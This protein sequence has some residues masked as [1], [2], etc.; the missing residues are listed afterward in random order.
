MSIRLSEDLQRS[1]LKAKLPSLPAMAVQLLGLGQS[2]SSNVAALTEIV[3]NDPAVTAAL[4]RLANAAAYHRIKPAE[5]LAQATSHLG[6]ERSRMIAMSATLLPTLRG[7]EGPGLCYQEFWRRSLIAGSTARAIGQQL[8]PDDVEPIFLAAILQDVGILALAQLPSAIYNGIDCSEYTH[9]VAIEHER[10][11]IQEDH[12]AVGA[13]LLEQ[14]RFPARFVRAVR[15]SNTP[16]IV[17]VPTE[18]E[19]FSSLITA[20]GLLADLWMW[21]GRSHPKLILY[22]SHIT[23]LLGLDWQEVIQILADASSDIPLV[24]ALCGVQIDNVKTMH[25]ALSMLRDRGESDPSIE[26]DL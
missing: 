1:L 4:I 25:M 13:W 7:V 10:E 23:K 11:A 21:A 5:T 8:R 19:D 24:E 20:A 17:P 9:E 16:G 14:W 12:G 6:Y 2:A 15:L 26:G 3:S 22:Q 18:A